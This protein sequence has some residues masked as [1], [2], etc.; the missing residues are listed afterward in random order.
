MA[1]ELRQAH[2][3]ETGH[4]SRFLLAMAASAIAF[5]FHET[6]DR[7]LSWSLALVGLAVFGWAISFAAGPRY[8][9]C[10]AGAYKANLMGLKAGK[11]GDPVTEAQCY[12]AAESFNDKGSIAAEVQRWALLAGALLYAIGHVWYL[13]IRAPLGRGRA[14]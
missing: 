4:S 8:S 6:T 2:R 1:E 3:E 13:P 5:A 11:R 14:P 9:S 12:D 10:R 7:P